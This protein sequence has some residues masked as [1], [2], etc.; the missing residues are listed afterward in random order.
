MISNRSDDSENRRRKP[1]VKEV[2]MNRHFSLLTVT[3][4]FF[5]FFISGCLVT[6]GTYMK[7]AGELDNRTKEL[8]S[9]QQKCQDENNTLKERAATLTADRD[10]LK[11]A[12][13]L[14]TKEKTELEKVLQSKSDALTKNIMELRKKITDLE[15]ENQILTE[16]LIQMKHLREEDVESIKKVQEALLQEMKEEISSGQVTITELKGRLSV[17]IQGKALF[18]AGETEVRTEG[19]AIL[20]RLIDILKNVKGKSIRVEGHA[21]TVNP[22]GQTSKKYPTAWELAASRA[23]T[24]TRLLQKQGV[25]PAGLSAVSYGEYKP[26][27]ESSTTESQAMN[28][29][30]TIIILPKE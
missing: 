24:V 30:I 25:D 12:F 13:A 3:M 21:D 8:A 28:R 2:I 27:A 14:A 18:D 6:Q 11:E 23:I 17:D 10:Q 5:S 29:R 15:G 20:Q 19:L 1:A 16:N 7:T 26:I 4:A 9:V 22:K